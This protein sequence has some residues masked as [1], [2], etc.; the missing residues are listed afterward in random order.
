MHGYQDY[1]IAKAL[2]LDT[3]IAERIKISD[4]E[5]IF[6]LSSVNSPVSQLLQEKERNGEIVTYGTRSS[7]FT[8]RNQ[9]YI[10]G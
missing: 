10:E 8:K 2:N 1:L 7:R 9:Q 4:Y 3:H 6:S 5:R